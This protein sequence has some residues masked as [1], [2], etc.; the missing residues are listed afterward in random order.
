MKILVKFPT[1][2]RPTQFMK[3]LSNYIALSEDP[4]NVHYLITLDS[5]DPRIHTYKAMLDEQ[6]YEN[7]KY[8]IGF[9]KGKIH[10]CNRDMEHAGEWDI[11][12]LASDDMVPQ[13]QGWDT[14]LRL[15]MLQFHPD[16]DGVLF[17]NDG[18]LGRKLNTMCILG[19]KYFE[20]FKTIYNTEYKSLWCDNEFTEVA[21]ILGRQTYFEQCL[22]KHEHFSTNAAVKADDLMSK[23]QTFFYSDKKIYQTRKLKNFDL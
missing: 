7:V 23:N 3:M 19:R 12:M 11:V 5:N 22:F 21:D 2:E 10:A 9:S 16:T 17:H 14:I 4:A 13:V 15:E 6:N 20:R 1:R 18:Y 8:V